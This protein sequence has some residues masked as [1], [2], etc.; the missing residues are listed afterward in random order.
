MS[1]DEEGKE[2]VTGEEWVS[3]RSE[4][5]AEICCEKKKAKE[6]VKLK[7]ATE[8]LA[9]SEKQSLGRGSDNHEQIAKIEILRELDI[10]YWTGI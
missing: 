6:N 7:Q 8:L 5:R 1:G 3:K 9:S 2:R 4:R 10:D